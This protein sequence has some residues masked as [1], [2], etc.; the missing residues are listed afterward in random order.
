M[1]ASLV[2]RLAGEPRRFAAVVALG[3]AVFCS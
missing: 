3:L 2:R 1:I